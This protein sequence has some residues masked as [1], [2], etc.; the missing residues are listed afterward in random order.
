MAMEPWSP[1]RE[2]VTLRDAMDR[3]FQ[4]S[5]VR[6][7]GGMSGRGSVA[8]DIA[9]SADQYEVRAALPGVKPEDVQ[10]TV[11]GDNLTI[12]GEV[13]GEEERKTDQN[14]LARE[15]VTGT[16]Y[17]SISLPLP[18]SAEKAQA[19]FEHGILYLTLPKAEE[20][21]PKEIRIDGGSQA[22][23]IP[24]QGATSTESNH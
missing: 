3:L 6:P 22:R 2:M 12:R 4:E 21:K 10:I 9:E 11:Q 18:V 8:L 5:F 7:I 15:R 14:W 23:Q 20:A 1:Y 19:H 17:R 13:K 16:F 24:T